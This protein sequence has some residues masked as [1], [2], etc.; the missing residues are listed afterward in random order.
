MTGY[1]ILGCHFS[2]FTRICLLGHE[3]MYRRRPGGY[4][5]GRPRDSSGMALSLALSLLHQFNQLPNKPPATM[6][7]LAINVVA[8][9]VPD[10]LPPVTQ[11]CI[12]P[13]R[14]Q[15]PDAFL[16]RSFLAA[17]THADAVHL[18]ANMSSLMYKGY[19]LE[20]RGRYS[21][22]KLLLLVAELV[23]TSSALYCATAFIL[24]ALG[25]WQSCAV[26][27]SAVLFALKVV[28]HD[29][30]ARE[31]VHGSEGGFQTASWAE[32]LLGQFVSSHYGGMTTAGSAIGHG[33][34]VLAGLVHVHV[35]KRVLYAL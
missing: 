33:C 4:G 29:C 19:W 15:S 26:G 9:F 10:V 27:F 8:F 31:G 28:L 13:S 30:E 32:L 5:Y 22:T 18:Y 20:R 12:N 6:L 24:P 16:V 34:G 1:W 35:T 7:L 2:G 17:F 25:L 3:V 23:V 21:A 14:M 11:A